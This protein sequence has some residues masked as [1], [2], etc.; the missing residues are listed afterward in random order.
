MKRCR[1]LVQFGVMCTLTLSFGFTSVAFAGEAASPSS[2]SVSVNGKEVTL[3]GYLIHG[4][5]YYQIREI[6]QILKGTQ[7]EFQVEWNNTQNAIIL[8]SSKAYTS[9]ETM[10]KMKFKRLQRKPLSPTLMYI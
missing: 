5:N 9:K 3:D 2:L 7:K 4:N 10:K 1:K 8:S 6:A